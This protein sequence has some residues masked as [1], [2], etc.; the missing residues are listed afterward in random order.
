MGKTFRPWNVGQTWH[1]SAPMHEFVPPGHLA[2]CVREASDLSAIVGVCKGEQGQ[3]ANCAGL[4]G[5]AGRNGGCRSEPAGFL[6]H[7]QLP[8]P[9]WSSWG[10]ARWMAGLADRRNR[11]P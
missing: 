9:A 8:R 3:P 4:P 5:P 10:M 7:Q 2:H 11:P 6:H 1:L